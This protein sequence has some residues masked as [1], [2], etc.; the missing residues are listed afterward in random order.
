M[1]AVQFSG[2]GAVWMSVIMI[3]YGTTFTPS[4]TRSFVMGRDDFSKLFGWTTGPRKRHLGWPRSFHL[5]PL[6][7]SV[8][9]ENKAAFMPTSKMVTKYSGLNGNGYQMGAQAVL[10]YKTSSFFGFRSDSTQFSNAQNN[11][12]LD[13]HRHETP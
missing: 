2:A 3:D 8:E 5:C 9:N 4:T 7:T 6:G 13:F 11:Q 1:E 10:R 12:D